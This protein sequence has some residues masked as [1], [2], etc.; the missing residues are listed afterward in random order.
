MDLTQ[1]KKKLYIVP[2]QQKEIEKLKKTGHLT[3][4]QKNW[5]QLKQNGK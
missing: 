2:G 1:K 4:K 3:K 5:L